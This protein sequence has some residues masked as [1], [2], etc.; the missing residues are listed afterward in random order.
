MTHFENH[1]TNYGNNKRIKR[2]DL[3]VKR[4][5]GIEVDLRDKDIVTVTHLVCYLCL[6]LLFFYL[7]CLFVLFFCVFSFLSVEFIVFHH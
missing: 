7:N 2:L 1:K 6:V 3:T 5:S 4:A